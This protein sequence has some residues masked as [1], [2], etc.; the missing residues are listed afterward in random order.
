MSGSINIPHLREFGWVRINR[1]VPVEYCE[2]LVEV[3]ASELGVPI[4]NPTRWDL[5]G[6]EMQDLVPIW[7]HQA[8]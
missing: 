6:G 3:L 4:H 7:G 2:R 1:A 8:Q 5:Y